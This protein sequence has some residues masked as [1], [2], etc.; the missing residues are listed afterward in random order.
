MSCLQICLLS[1]PVSPLF[2]L[3]AAY[4]LVFN[5]LRSL[6]SSEMEKALMLVYVEVFVGASGSTLTTTEKFGA[7]A[8]KLNDRGRE[9]GLKSQ[10]VILIEK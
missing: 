5:M 3:L 1:L 2:S 9:G 10:P 8:Q 7:I 4:F 6:F